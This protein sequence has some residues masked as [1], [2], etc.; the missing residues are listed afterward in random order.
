MT[1]M[2]ARDQY[3][4]ADQAGVLEVDDP[5]ELILVT[6]RELERALRTL[7]A[8]RTQGRPYGESALNR[9]F[10]AIYILQSSLDFEKGGEVATSLFQVYEY[11]RMQVVAAFRREEVTL[12]AE[13]AT[14]IADL[15][16]AWTEIRPEGLRK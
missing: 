15:M 11:C 10:T 3:R 9:A 13:A 16:S 8:A 6:M 7:A 2:F 4:K 12:L 5:H 14:D 1:A